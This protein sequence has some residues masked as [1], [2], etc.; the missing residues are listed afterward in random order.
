MAGRNLSI[1]TLFH[2]QKTM[3]NVA[4]TTKVN[5]ADGI[6][7]SRHPKNNDSTSS[8]RSYNN[9]LTNMTESVASMRA[10]GFSPA[11][12]TNAANATSRP[13]IVSIPEDPAADITIKLLSSSSSTIEE[14]DE[15]KPRVLDDKQF[16]A[17][18]MHE[19]IVARGR[20]GL[21]SLVKNR[22]RTEKENSAKKKLKTTLKTLQK[23]KDNDGHIATILDVTSNGNDLIG[24]PM[25]NSQ[26]CLDLVMEL[27]E[28]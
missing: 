1:G 3:M 25:I 5:T 7:D 20:V 2:L 6:I 14:D 12:A 22:N 9:H 17:S 21:T 16:A 27:Y 8:H 18:E 10:N 23:E 15:R 26:D 28:D 11:P 4:P 19:R 13:R 24:S